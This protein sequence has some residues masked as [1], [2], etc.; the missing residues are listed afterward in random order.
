MATIW[1]D[2]DDYPDQRES[3]QA[4]SPGARRMA[5][6]IV[7]RANRQPTPLFDEEALA[8]WQ[9][10]D[11]NNRLTP[12]RQLSPDDAL[13]ACYLLGRRDMA[14]LGREY[15]EEPPSGLVPLLIGVF[16]GC[17]GGI[18]LGVLLAGQVVSSGWLR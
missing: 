10:E 1:G 8:Y 15:A 11:R 7:Y 2:C 5:A 9:A 6:A 14:T 13:V 4:P 16:G 18:M 12:R 17:L 3:E